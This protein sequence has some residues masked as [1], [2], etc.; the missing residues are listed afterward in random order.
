[1]TMNR[2]LRLT[3][4]LA[5]AAALFA[6]AVA[7]LAPAE[8][9]RARRPRP[10]RQN[11]REQ[12]EGKPA[13]PEE[14]VVRGRVVY[15]ETSRPV[16]RG[17]VV[18]ITDG[19]A[20]GHGEYAALTDARGDFRIKGV[21]PGTYYAYV[22]APGV[23]SPVGFVSIEEMRLSS[24]VPDLGEARKF[25]DPVEVDGRADVN[26][27]VHARRGA[28][29]SG[30]VA[31]A[32]GDPAVNVN[33][34]LMR[35]S[36]DGR[37]RQYLTGATAVALA[38]LRTD[39]RGMFRLTGLPPG[40]YLVGVSESV[41]HGSADV[42]TG[43][44]EDVSGTFR[45]MFT[46]QLLMTFYPSATS[47]KEARVV[48]VAAGDERADVDINIPERDL[49][50]LGGV[51]RARRGGAPVRN[52]RVS[53]TLRD[54]PLALTGPAAAYY[55]ASGDGPNSTTTDDQ[56]RWQLH[57]IPDGAY[58]ISVKPPE[59]YEDG[60]AVTGNMNANSSVTTATTGNANLSV[61][62]I[63]TN[64]SEYRPPRRKRSYAPTRVNLDVSGGDVSEFVVEVSDGA[65]V[66]GTVSVE[67]GAAPRYGSISVVCLS[68]GGTA[69]D[70]SGTQSGSLDGGRFAIEGLPAGRF[71]LQPTI[72]GS[73]GR[74]YL[75]SITWN[76]KD[77]L[78]EPLELADG[79]S[80]EGVRVVYGRNPATLHVTVRP[81]AGKRRPSELFILLV[82]ADLSL[83]SPQ[84]QP[85]FC[86]TGE[87]GTCPV[88]APPGEYRLLVMRSPMSPVAYEQEVRRRAAGAPRVTL[89]EGEPGRVEVDAPDN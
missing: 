59:E 14:S 71:V 51:V 89:R 8:A 50:I 76:G 24:G 78:R 34:G 38:G 1:M 21:H 3:K 63:N 27:T 32:D 37:V 57:E 4:W 72:E 33:V 5:P 18:L 58:V 74:T 44:S 86:V 73:D 31:Y 62:S 30:R 47:L 17:R 36:A 82:P 66:T 65:R 80:A 35:R 13:A 70:F 28:A 54:D 19:G 12:Q 81:A 60:T 25:F 20:T 2:A 52:A 22:D 85:F 23:L 67:G 45:G 48:K 84:V 88:N 9:G 53:I 77:L 75:K 16:R 64:A 11:M 39:D 10:P 6:L 15:D 46:P 42:A 43:M 29:I 7:L 26:V 79:A 68:E 87:A 40:E 49:R 83:W 61:T 41:N 56:G 55:D 69:P